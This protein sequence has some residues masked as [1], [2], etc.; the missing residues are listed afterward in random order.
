MSKGFLVVAENNN[1]IDFIKMAYVLALSLKTTQTKVK[2]LSIIT[3]EKIT[4]KKYLDIFDKVIVI[5]K[6]PNWKEKSNSIDTT[7][8]CAKYYDVTPYDETIVLDTDIIF[9]KDISKWWDILYDK[10]LIFTYNVKTFRNQEATSDYYRKVFTKN[11]LPNLYT[12]LFY[13]KKSDIAEVFFTMTNTVFKDWEVFYEQLDKKYRPTSLSADLAY[14]ISYKLLGLPDYSYLPIPTFTH[15]K[16]QLQ[17]IG[18]IEEEWTK[19]L[20]VTINN[21]MD[22]KINNYSQ[23]Y[24]FHYHDKKFLTEELIESYEKG[25]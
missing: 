7:S 14:S 12:G 21:K 8:L 4:T 23:K 17:D 22:I 2:N 9:T 5:D 16:S 20:S 11:S 24:P 3:T 1:N 13:F 10:D 19:H 6:D 25:I 18:K 15:M